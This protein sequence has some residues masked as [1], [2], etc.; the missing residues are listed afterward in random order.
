MMNLFRSILIL[1]IAAGALS[2]R[3]DDK[4][5]IIKKEEEKID[6]QP[7]TW[8]G[9]VADNSTPVY[10]GCACLCGCCSIPPRTTVCSSCYQRVGL[11]CCWEQTS[12]HVHNPVGQKGQGWEQQQRKEDGD[13][14]LHS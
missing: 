7:G 12:C 1:S 10:S 8:L 9:T 6:R 14:G 3:A 4:E 5:L 2:L 13:L 11:E